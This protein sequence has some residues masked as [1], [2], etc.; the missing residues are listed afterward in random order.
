[1]KIRTRRTSSERAILAGLAVTCVLLGVASVG[2]GGCNAIG[3]LSDYHIQVPD[4]SSCGVNHEACATSLDVPGGTYCRNFDPVSKTCTG[5]APKRT[6]GQPCDPLY[7]P[8]CGCA[9]GE[10][11]C[12][13]SG[14]CDAASAQAA[15]FGLSAGFKATVSSFRLDKFE[16]TVGRF[17]VFVNEVVSTGWN[18]APGAGKHTHLQG[19][20]LNGGSEPGWNGAALPSAKA[21][22][23]ANLGAQGGQQCTW[24]PDPGSNETLPINCISWSEAYA[25]CI[26]DGGFLPSEAEWN[27]AATGGSAR[28]DCSDQRIYPWGDDAPD[29]T[30]LIYGC[31]Y[32][33]PTTSDLGPGFIGN[34]AHSGGTNIAPVGSR[35]LG[36]G[37]FG[38]SDLA[39][40]MLEWTLDW[41]GPPATNCVD[42]AVGS[43]DSSSSNR[44][45]RGEPFW[46]EAPTP[47][48]A[49]RENRPPDTRYDFVGAR[50]ARSPRP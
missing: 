8:F 37:A 33:T 36:N 21:V 31:G 3:G 14:P 49:Q 17:R 15:C 45:V 26:W 29:A 35:P 20:G 22:W 1:M 46:G 2:F 18:P 41:V 6:D 24:T 30:K 4:V 48:A 34:C 43:S 10:T 12:A 28:S 50:C 32:P 47:T 23:D 11:C 7:A 27:Y 42:C 25:F 40:S 5:P 44:V 39:G 9:A 19:G 38:Q 16:V 13:A